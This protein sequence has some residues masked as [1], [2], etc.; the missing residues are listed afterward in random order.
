MNQFTN[1]FTLR[2]LTWSVSDETVQLRGARVVE[3]GGPQVLLPIEIAGFSRTQFGGHM[4]QLG[5]LALGAV[6]P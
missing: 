4:N 6:C 2:P 1:G 3:I 5:G